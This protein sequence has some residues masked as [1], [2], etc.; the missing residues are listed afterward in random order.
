MRRIE[1]GKGAKEKGKANNLDGGK[2][3]R[4]MSEII[5]L[6][7]W[8]LRVAN[9]FQFHFTVHFEVYEHPQHI[10]DPISMENIFLSLSLNSILLHRWHKFEVWGF[11]VSIIGCFESILLK[12]IGLGINWK[13]QAIAD[14]RTSP[15]RQHEIKLFFRFS[16]A[17]DSASSSSPLRKTLSD[18]D[19]KLVH[20]QFCLT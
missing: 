9:Y 5:I 16:S 3:Q 7:D 14:P 6:Q 11:T 18:W 13:L 15:N 4:K 20:F 1:I 8:P 19:F 12:N 17:S 2:K 10:D